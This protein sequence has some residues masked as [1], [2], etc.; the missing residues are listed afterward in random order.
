MSEPQTLPG[1]GISAATR[2]C[3]RCYLTIDSRA[4]VCGHCQFAVTQY[5]ENL[6]R[7]SISRM[8]KVQV[9]QSGYRFK[10]YK[11]LVGDKAGRS[12]AFALLGALVG[13]ILLLIPVIGW[14][15]GGLL[16]LGALWH[17]V[18]AFGAPLFSLFTAFSPAE[19]AAKRS[20]EDNTYTDVECPSCRVAMA[21]WKRR[22]IL[23]WPDAKDSTASC[24][25]CK[26]TLYRFGDQ[27]LWIPHA[28]VSVTGKL[29]E[30]LN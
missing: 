4:L 12:L 28:Q 3:P 20:R 19:Q 26:A 2:V 23:F 8:R 29:S 16:L 14:L 9:A 7:R 6:A 10:R 21:S 15:V 17:L 11:A 24:K 18:A 30:F 13:A 22:T 25:N 27:L 1:Q 5:D